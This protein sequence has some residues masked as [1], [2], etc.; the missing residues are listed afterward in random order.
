MLYWLFKCFLNNL[1]AKFKFF[2]LILSASSNMMY[3]VRTFSIKRA[4]GVRL[5]AVEKVRNYGKIVYIKNIF[6]NSWWEHA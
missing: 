6:E 2:D 4:L 1:H 5:I 3:F